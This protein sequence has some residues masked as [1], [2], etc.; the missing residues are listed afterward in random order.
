[1]SEALPELLGCRPQF[2]YYKSLKFNI[3]IFYLNLMNTSI[4]YKKNVHYHSSFL[5][6]E[7]H[8][9]NFVIP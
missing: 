6:R 9:N 7:I 2:R 5:R 1:M 4:Y 3:D 8:C